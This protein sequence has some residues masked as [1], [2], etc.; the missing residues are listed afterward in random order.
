MNRRTF[1][2]TVIVTPAVAALLAAC[3]DD[4]A[5]PA[6]T[7]P[8]TG[9]GTT[10]T[11]TGP[12]TTS[13]GGGVT[14]VGH[15]TGSTD[16]VLRLGYEG[17][18]ITAD[19]F[20]SQSPSLVIT[21]DGVVLTQGAVPAIYPGPLVMPFF[22]R[23]IDEV[24]IQAVLVAA[25]DA[26][27]LATAPDYSLPNGIGISDAADTVL[28]INANGARYEHR[29]YAL[30]ITAA[31]S[32]ASTPA[33]DA[34]AAFI[35]RASDLPKLAG[36]E[37]VGTEQPYQPVAYRLRA[38]PVDP[39]PNAATGSTAPIEPQPTVSPWPADTGVVLAQASTCVV[40][41]AAK[42]GAVLTGA[43]QLSYF[44]EG[45]ITYQLAVVTS[46]PGDTGC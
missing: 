38:T 11:D 5:V 41:D 9:P 40:A 1:L 35:G 31:D 34:L 27:L 22:Q 20:F 29:A 15:P 46:L 8:D 39:P 32:R 10:T 21:G 13:P 7:S 17:G 26:G 4:S 6:D 14:G 12:G 19:A 24:G 18:F 44:S 33:R 30:D 43:T 45:G 42:V 36:S 28:V 23:S 37:H 25:N 16:A 3:G 2:T